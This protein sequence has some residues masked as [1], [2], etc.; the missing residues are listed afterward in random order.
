MEKRKEGEKMV[1]R[2]IVKPEYPEQK[3]ITRA[4]ADL[5]RI[6]VDIRGRMIGSEPVAQT[7][8]S[9]LQTRVK[10]SLEYPDPTER[11]PYFVR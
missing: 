2:I 4:L 3:G 9:S 6:Q 7:G 11:K 8:S 1:E 5:D 10:I